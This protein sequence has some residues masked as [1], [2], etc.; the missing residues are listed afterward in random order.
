MTP[1][2]KGVTLGKFWLL[3]NVFLDRVRTFSKHYQTNYYILNFA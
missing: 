2:I 3:A 1:A